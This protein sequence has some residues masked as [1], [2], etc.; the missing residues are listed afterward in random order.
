MGSCPFAS[1][2]HEKGTDYKPSFGI[3]IGS[4]SGYH[5]FSCGVKG[6]LFTLPSSLSFVV[7]GDYTDLSS[8]IESHESIEFVIEEEVINKTMPA[9]PIQ[10]YHQFKRAF[11]WRGI[12][13]KDID[14]WDLRVDIEQKNYLFPI[15]DLMGRLVGIRGRSFVNTRDFKSYSHLSPINKDAKSFGMWFGM[16]NPLIPDKMLVLVEG[17][18]DAILLR[19]AG[20]KNVWASMGA[21]ITDSQIVS[22]K[23]IPYKILLFFDND[24]A[25]KQA[26]DKVISECSSVVKALFYISDYYGA[27]DPAEAVEKGIIK[28]VLSSA[29]LCLT[30]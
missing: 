5:C 9:I 14:L 20:V 26:M 17:E 16:G 19:R 30:K 2:T 29:K 22:I 6:T 7:G 12:T 1:V 21:S 8:Y 13:E 28:K 18:R 24:K 10:I 11:S 23:S 3:K 4:P 25:G 27:K 15:F